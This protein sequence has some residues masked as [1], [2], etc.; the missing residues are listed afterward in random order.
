MQPDSKLIRAALE[1]LLQGESLSMP[2]MQAVMLEIMQGHANDAQIAAF[3][4]ALRIKGESVAELEGSVRAM[5]DLMK[6]VPLTNLDRTVDIVGTGGTSHGAD[7]VNVSTASAL[8]AAAAGARVAKHGNRSAS[9]V[10]GS[11]D[12]LEAAGVSLELDSKQIAR[13]IETLGIGFM[14]APQHHPA[15]RH[16]IGVRRALGIRTIFNLLGPMTNPTGLTHHLIGAYA[17]EWCRPMAEVL[18]QLGSVHA[19]VV[20]SH[21][22]LDELSIAA[23]NQVV[24]LKDG[25]ITEYQLR[26]EDVGLKTQSIALLS[27]TDAKDSLRLIKDTFDKQTTAASVVAAQMIAF[28][29]GAALHI[30]GVTSNIKQGVELAM[31]VIHSGQALEKLSILSEFTHTLQ[32]TTPI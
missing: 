26:A 13:C 20:H 3:L 1:P 21:D 23:P 12:V 11:A 14:F 32:Q 17:L 28:N 22:G 7:L 27:I 2:E 9:S 31:D 18:Q 4:V 8:V 6:R 30:A 25:E 29:A 24:S 19:L 5:R 15:M 16:A 10:S